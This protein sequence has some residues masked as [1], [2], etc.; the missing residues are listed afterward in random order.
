MKKL[1]TVVLLLL[2]FN[3]FAVD[4]GLYPTTNYNC[5]VPTEREDD[6]PFDWATEGKEIRFYWGTAT[7]DYQNI[8][9]RPACQWVIDNTAFPANTTIYI[10]T[11]AVDT[12]NRESR[13][14]AEVTHVMTA[15][16]ADPKST[17]PG[18]LEHIPAQ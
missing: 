7:G 1:L 16:K 4:V 14:N 11:T 15:A 10:V 9:T 2:S 18:T 3:A 12:E 6:T 13:Y 17:G 8:V 5:V